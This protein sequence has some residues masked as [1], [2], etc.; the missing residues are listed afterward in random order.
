[1]AKK[2]AKSETV[3]EQAAELLTT[4]ATVAEASMVQAAEPKPL[5]LSPPAIQRAIAQGSALITEGKSKAD[6]A[7]AI[8]ASIKDEP[9]DVIVA[10]FVEGATLTPKGALTYWYNCRRKASKERKQD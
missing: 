8:F 6:A 10:A 7:R 4:A 1:M 3:I 9:K 2:S 5:D